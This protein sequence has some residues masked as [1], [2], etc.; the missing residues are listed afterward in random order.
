M[1][2]VVVARPGGPE[3]LRVEERPDPHAGD[4]EVVISVA[5]A[6]VNRADLLQRQGFYPPP[7][8]ASEVLGL[9]ASGVIKE[10]G[11]RVEGLATGDKVMALLEGGGYA[12]L[13]AVRATQVVRV[14]DN[15]DLID[16]GGIP[17]VFI[18]AHDA[19]FTRGR[20]GHDETVLI[21]GGGGGVGTAAI[22]LARLHGCRVIVTAGS[23]EKLARCIELGAEVGINYKTEDFVARTREVTAGRGADVVLDIMGASYLER[24]LDVVA[25]DGRVV[26]IGM[27]G[28]T[29]TDIDLAVMMRRRISLIST[30]LRARPAQQ[31]AVIVA[32]FA[33]DVVPALARRT[34]RPVVDRTLTF[35]EAADAHRLMESGGAVGKIV[36]VPAAHG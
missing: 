14:P 17:E 2:A 13:A 27:Q 3:E 25:S 32:A 35:D 18:T 16:A 1:R 12:E 9:E 29:H 36:L 19:L 34:L 23:A 28:G 10:I 24:N 33:A 15:V 8:G 31:K 20:L 7:P 11:V 4:G 26:V 22:Q 21:H 30:A 5:G 6:G